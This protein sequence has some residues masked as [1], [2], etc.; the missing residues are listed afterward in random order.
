MA[1]HAHVDTGFDGWPTDYLVN[2]FGD[3]QAQGRF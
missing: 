2:R 1:A 3:R